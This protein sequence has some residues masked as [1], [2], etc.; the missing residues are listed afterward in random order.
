[1]S[2]E[3]AELRE[4]ARLALYELLMKTD[5]GSGQTLRSAYNELKWALERERKTKVAEAPDP[6]K[7]EREREEARE[8][9]WK[10]MDW[11][12]R[13]RLLLETL[14]DESLTKREI[15]TRINAEHDDLHVY[16]SNITGL[17]KR[18]V[19]RRELDQIAEQWKNR[20]RYRY[21][22]RADLDGPIADLERA[23]GEG[24]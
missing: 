20:L 21:R 24:S 12:A 3:Y 15:R 19:E 22:R 10:G 16:E 1:M 5:P 17:L 13:E 14:R 4:T 6:Q 9:A 11:P 2:E 8:D 18:M 23:L 7:E